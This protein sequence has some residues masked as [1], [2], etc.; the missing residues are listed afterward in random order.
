MSGVGAR[1]AE[2]TEEHKVFQASTVYFEAKKVQTRRN[3]SIGPGAACSDDE[4]GG[5]DWEPQHTA[6][7]APG[8]HDLD[9]TVRE[10]SRRDTTFLR[11]SRENRRTSADSSF[12]QRVPVSHEEITAVPTPPY[13]PFATHASSPASEQPPAFSDATTNQAALTLEDF[14]NSLN[15]GL[16][17]NRSK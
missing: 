3:V 14:R 6:P 10:S 9:G 7:S 17:N 2:I 5:Y 4:G 11:L 16:R 12:F 8:Y 15:A 13:S 1:R